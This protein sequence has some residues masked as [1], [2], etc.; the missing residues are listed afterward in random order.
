MKKILFTLL[1]LS[2][3]H[4]AFSQA[5]SK[6]QK[7]RELLEETGAVKISLQLVQQIF[8]GFRDR[9]KEVPQDVWD[10]LMAGAKMEE[11]VSLLIPIYA[12]YY[13]EEELDGL[14]QFY[15]S[16]L[17]KKTIAITPQVMQESMQV[18]S[19]WGKQLA[20]KIL[21]ELNEKGYKP[22]SEG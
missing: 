2:V 12:K 1:F 20:A 9:F 13:T 8:G 19:Q 22:K 5:S 21:R 17:G 14:L 18:G 7:V 6:E 16:P 3:I 10:K 15:R 11:I 4:A